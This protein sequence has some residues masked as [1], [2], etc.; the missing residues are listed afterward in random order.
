M[1][2]KLIK[3]FTVLHRNIFKLQQPEEQ[4]NINV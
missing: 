2:G 3:G 4:L 1:P